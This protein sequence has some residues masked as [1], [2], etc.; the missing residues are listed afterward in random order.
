MRGVAA[1]A[2]LVAGL[3]AVVFEHAFAD[4]VAAGGQRTFPECAQAVAAMV[5]SAVAAGVTAARPRGG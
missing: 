5:R 4:W 3:A 2:S 1:E